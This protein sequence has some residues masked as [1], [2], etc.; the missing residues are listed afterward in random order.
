ML[1]QYL[2]V[3]SLNIADDSYRITFAPEL[4]ELK[5][6]V[7]VAG[8]IQPINVRHTPEGTYQ[9]VTGYKRVL[10]MQELERQ[11]I[12]ALIHEPNDLSPT[13]AFLWSLH[14]NAVA[15]SLNLIEKSVA[16]TKLNQ[17]YQM[18]EDEL[19]KQFLPL[20]GEEPS[21]KILHQLMSLDSL[22]EPVK[23][24]VVKSKVAL[25]SASR[26]S[27]FTP[28]TQQ[29]LLGVLSH[30]NPST[31]KLNELLALLRE[32]SARDGLTVEDIL[33]RYQLL[34]VVVNPTATSADKVS[35]L[36]QALRGIR[37]PQLTERQKQLAHLIQ[38]LE[39]PTQAKVVADPYFENK[40]MKLECQFSHP[41]E[42][43]S[44]IKKIQAAFE[45]QKWQEIFEWYRT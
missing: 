33:S 13:Q 17:F 9:I 1:L 20:I 24:H 6:S 3:S 7:K 34:Q 38:G 5:R 44:V 22:T 31:N 16:L 19:A 30:I 40:N 15:R 45:K 8:I 41:E 26:M 23:T 28:S 4:E 39:L 36:R 27:E 18:S 37:L 35:A 25:S 32:I 42:L 11:S 12:P 29:A 10:V 14:D 2:N 21:F 43:D